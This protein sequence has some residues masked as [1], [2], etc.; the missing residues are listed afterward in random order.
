MKKSFVSFLSFLL[1]I[2]ITV[3]GTL[4][5][6]AYAYEDNSVLAENSSSD[7]AE[8]VSSDMSI[9][10]A[11]SNVDGYYSLNDWTEAYPQG[12]YVVEYNT[13]ELTEG[14]T[15]PE[16]PEDV[17]VGVVVYR[18]GGCNQ[19]ATVRYTT[20]C[21]IGDKETYPTSLGELYFAPGEDRATA[22]IRIVNDDKRTG[23]QLLVF[24]LDSATSGEISVASAAGIKIFD[25]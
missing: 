3:S 13:Y 5:V 4:P 6:I 21:S 1:A 12:L 11:K 14:G 20:S 18:I 16:N 25:D 10:S 22:N 23:N 15:D 17:Y 9:E 19:A 7:I 2:I 24:A 8:I